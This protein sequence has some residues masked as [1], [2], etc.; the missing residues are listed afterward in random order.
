MAGFLGG[1]ALLTGLVLLPLSG[2]FYA[3]SGVAS[4]FTTGCVATGG[5][6]AAVAAAVYLGDNVLMVPE[7]LATLE[8]AIQEAR[9]WAKGKRDLFH[10]ER[11]EADLEAL[12]LK[13]GRYVQTLILFLVCL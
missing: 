10:L 11:T 2:I 7:Y 12:L 1:L 9:C 5:G 13:E 4:M 6:A 8:Y 3:V